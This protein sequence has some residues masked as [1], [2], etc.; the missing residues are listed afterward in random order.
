M[1]RRESIEHMLKINLEDTLDF[2][3][4]GLYNSAC[5]NR[6]MEDCGDDRDCNDCRAVWLDTEI[7]DDAPKQVLNWLEKHESDTIDI[8]IRFKGLCI[9]E[10]ME[11][12]KN[13]LIVQ[14]CDNYI[15]FCPNP[16]CSLGFKPLFCY[17][18]QQT[19]RVF[20]EEG[21]VVFTIA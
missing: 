15:Y 16:Q 9:L 18:N 10:E 14:G 4:D 1:T 11:P 2:L 8:A 12:I 19:L 5:N 20:T 17:A 7:T 3:Q 13:Q 21:S 6:S